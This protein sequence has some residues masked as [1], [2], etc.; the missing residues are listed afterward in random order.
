MAH[1]YLQDTHRQ[2]ASEDAT[3]ML[4]CNLSSNGRVIG[5][6][7]YSANYLRKHVHFHS[8]RWQAV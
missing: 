1:E 7:E 6:L 8:E 2:T 3:L 4:Q 5:A